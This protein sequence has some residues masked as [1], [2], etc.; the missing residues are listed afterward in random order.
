VGANGLRVPAL[1]HDKVRE[2]LA[3]HGRLER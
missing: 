2:L 1:P 3:K